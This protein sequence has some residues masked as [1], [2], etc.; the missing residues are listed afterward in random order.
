MYRIN[1]K[2]E[3]KSNE[4]GD[5]CVDRIN[6]REDDMNYLIIKNEYDDNFIMLR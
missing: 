6:E 3:N 1:W 4:G 2:Y 5:G